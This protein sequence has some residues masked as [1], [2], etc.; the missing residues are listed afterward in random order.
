MKIAEIYLVIENECYFEAARSSG[1]GG[2]N[3]NKVNS[4][5]IFIWNINKSVLPNQIK[6][7][8]FEK[9]KNRLS[10]NGDLVLHS[11]EFRDQP[12]NKANALDKMRTLVA[13][14]MFV[15]KVRKTT[16]PSRSSKEK[17]LKSKKTLQEKKKLRRRIDW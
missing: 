12:R 11:Q 6:L 9:W 2:Q 15:P 4:K 10:G 13:E 3:V 8:L 7:I 1:A 5:I 17:R 14:A 16:R